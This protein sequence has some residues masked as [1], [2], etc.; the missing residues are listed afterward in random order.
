MVSNYS[1]SQGMSPVASP[2][3]SPVPPPSP[4]VFQP[5]SADE[6]RLRNFRRVDKNIYLTQRYQY[7]FVP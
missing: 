5:L 6:E 7:C 2:T 1:P 3:P 4:K